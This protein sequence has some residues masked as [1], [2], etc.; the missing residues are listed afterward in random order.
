VDLGLGPGK[1]LPF[2]KELGETSLAFL[3]HPT[4]TS[5]DVAKTCDVVAKVC[6]AA[7]Q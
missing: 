2:A 5:Y 4:M 3:L 7:T 6:K 1:R